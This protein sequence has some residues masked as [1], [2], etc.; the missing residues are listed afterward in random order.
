MWQCRNPTLQSVIPS[1]LKSWAT[2]LPLMGSESLMGVWIT[3]RSPAPNVIVL[4]N[5]RDRNTRSRDWQG[6]IQKPGSKTVWRIRARQLSLITAV[7]IQRAAWIS[8]RQTRQNPRSLAGTRQGSHSRWPGRDANSL[9][10]ETTPAPPSWSRYGMLTA[11]QIDR[12][13][14]LAGLCC[15][16]M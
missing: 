9:Y 5:I 11:Q 12:C 4:C 14:A 7:C 6:G 16:L 1:C 8:D 15:S 2:L 10:C 13:H 3:C